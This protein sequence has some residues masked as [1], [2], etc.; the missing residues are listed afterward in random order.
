[1]PYLQALAAYVLWG[2]FPLYW[3][4]LSRVD[5]VEVICYRILWSL[6]TLLVVITYI[7]QWSDIFDTLGDLR[8][9]LL[10]AT[11]ACLISANWLVFIWAVQH[12]AIIETSLGYFI[13]PL[14]N[15]LLGVGLF[16][17]R[18]P[19]VQWLAVGIAA[20]GLAIMTLGTGRFSWIA[21][22]LASTFAAYAAVKKMTRLPAVAGMGME[23]ATLMPLALGY[24]LWNAAVSQEAFHST[25]LH[26]LLALGGP[27][28]TLP[29]VLFAAAAKSVP[30]AAMGLLQYI[31]PSLQ[32]IIGIMLY[33]EPISLWQI[34]GF[35]CVWAAL[36]LLSLHALT[37]S[38]RKATATPVEHADLERPK[39]ANDL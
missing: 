11:A 17:E 33:R 6:M 12:D 14:L 5:S 16:G 18:L 13:N 15:V 19:K 20:V 30:L 23:T 8:R 38:L 34:L 2:I 22:V 26:L 25:Q 35:A 28:T 7:R 39:I 3:K 32:F 21:I 31:A 9:T 29:L 24:L 10:T 1:M 4:L 37:N 27:I 36:G